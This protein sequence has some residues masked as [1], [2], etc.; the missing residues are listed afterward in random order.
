MGW[1]VGEVC[2][3]PQKLDGRVTITYCPYPSSSFVIR[4]TG[5]A[6]LEA[7]LVHFAANAEAWVC[8]VNVAHD[9]RY[10][11]R[12]HFSPSPGADIGGA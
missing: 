5:K 6:I 12:P 4:E 7:G 11:T 1:A 10:K 2:E 9:A 3:R 8:R